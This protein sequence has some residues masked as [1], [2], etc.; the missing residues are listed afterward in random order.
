MAQE[1]KSSISGREENGYALYPVF[2]PFFPTLIF[3][4]HPHLPSSSL[5]KKPRGFLQPEILAR[6]SRTLAPPNLQPSWPG[7]TA[8][9]SAGGAGQTVG[10]K[11]SHTRAC[12]CSA[13]RSVAV[14]LQTLGLSKL[15]FDLSSQWLHWLGFR[16]CDM[17]FERKHIMLGKG[18][19]WEEA[20]LVNSG[21]SPS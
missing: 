5:T 1:H 21:Q 16:N 14:R 20:D 6:R 13:V 12:V 19:Y 10:L 15:R 4:L 3:L 2:L 8:H 17:Q 11:V 7:S 18:P 9:I